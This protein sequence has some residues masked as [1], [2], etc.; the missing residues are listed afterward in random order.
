ME[1]KKKLEKII[2]NNTV[3]DEDILKNLI[4]M[5]KLIRY[6]NIVMKIILI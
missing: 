4:Q 2:N 6:I 1:I 5:K 3:K